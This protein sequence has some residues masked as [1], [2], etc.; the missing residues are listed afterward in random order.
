MTQHVALD[1]RAVLLVMRHRMRTWPHNRHSAGQH[2]DKLRQFV[3]GRAAKEVA[4]A[5]DARIVLRGL[6]HDPVVFHHLHRAEFPHHDRLA[7]HPVAGLAEDH[8]AWRGD[9]DRQRNAAQH[10]G[11]QQQ[12]QRGEHDI[13]CALE[14][15]V[16]PGERRVIQRYHRHAV[17]FFN[18]RVQNV[19]GKHVRDQDHRAGRVGQLTHQVFDTGLFAHF[20]GEIDVV[21]FARARIF[22]QLVVVTRPVRRHA[23]RFS[24]VIHPH[25][26]EAQP[27]LFAKTVQ[28]RLPH[29]QIAGHRHV[30]LV[31][32]A[33]TQPACDKADQGTAD[34]HPDAG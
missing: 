28:Q 21:N 27:R 15:T 3:E 34:H 10:R 2:V 16:D 11:D 4:H 22:D 5:G 32:A 20:Q 29:G 33:V 30:T 6:S 12:N 9:F 26:V 8:R 13:F 31:I 7:V 25:H 17:H 14:Q 1:Q 19:E 24:I 23:A 18:T